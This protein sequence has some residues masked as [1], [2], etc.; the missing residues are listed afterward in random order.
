[1]GVDSILMGLCNRDVNMT[2]EFSYC[3]CVMKCGPPCPG[4]D[5]EGGGCSATSVTICQRI[6]AARRANTKA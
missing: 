2:S 4:G 1:M 3:L 5:G 6:G